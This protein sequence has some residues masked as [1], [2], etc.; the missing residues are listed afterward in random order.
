MAEELPLSSDYINVE[1][2][3]RI[4]TLLKDKPLVAEF[5]VEDAL[6]NV[7]TGDKM[8]VGTKW[9]F[10]FEP[11]KSG[12]TDKRGWGVSSTEPF[13]EEP[14]HEVSERGWGRFLY[15]CFVLD[16]PD[17]WKEILLEHWESHIGK[18]R[19]G[20]TEKSLLGYTPQLD[21]SIPAQELYE[22]ELF[23]RVGGIELAMVSILTSQNKD[24]VECVKAW[25]RIHGEE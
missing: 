22:V 20:G 1:D 8:I 18:L 7:D 15:D 16:R 4:F 24:I 11:E 9:G 3:D 10:T 25:V 5:S 13:P 6:R 21:G 12:E 14:V 17:V 19:F 23:M 2:F